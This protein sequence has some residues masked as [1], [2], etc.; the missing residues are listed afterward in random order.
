MEAHQ[1]TFRTWE[2]LPDDMETHALSHLEWP[3]TGRR[4]P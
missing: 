4:K 1:H 2:C 3:S